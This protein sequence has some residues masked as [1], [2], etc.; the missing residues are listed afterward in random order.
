[1]YFCQK[2]TQTNPNN[3]FNPVGV[4]YFDIDY[5]SGKAYD[6]RDIVTIRYKFEGLKEETI[7]CTYF[8]YKNL[9][10]LPDMEICEIIK[11]ESE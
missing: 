11:N 1:M 8:Q 3:T 7:Q 10:D 4:S 9:K 2:R 6:N 5:M